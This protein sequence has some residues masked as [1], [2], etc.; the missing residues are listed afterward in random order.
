ML[1]N[2]RAAP[3]ET[4]GIWLQAGRNFSPVYSAAVCNWSGPVM[5]LAARIHL[6]H[7]KNDYSFKLVTAIVFAGV[8]VAFFSPNHALS[9]ADTTADSAQTAS[10][11]ANH[12]E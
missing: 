11:S 4:R 12:T 3:D 10:A 5:R 7:M 6:T 9:N 8:I 1:N 2:Q